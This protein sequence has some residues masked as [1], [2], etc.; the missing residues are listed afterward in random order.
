M[1]NDRTGHDPDTDNRVGA[2][3]EPPQPGLLGWLRA[4]RSVLRDPH[5]IIPD[6]Q[7][8]PEGEPLSESLD[9]HCPECNYN[10]TGLREWR[11]P[12]CGQRFDPRRA[13]TRRMLQRPEYVLRYRFDPA[14]IRSS[15]LAI[16]LFAA[17][18]V[19]ILAGGPIALQHGAVMFVSFLGVW[20]L[21]NMILARTQ[22][23][24]PWPNFLMFLSVLWLI[25]SALL[26]TVVTWM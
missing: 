9:L 8:P 17:G 6:V 13:H 2:P 21:P 22:G 26:L 18:V 19:L 3:P 7:L 4:W 25:A 10:L 15:F 12:E 14:E 1:V 11:C 16:L 24:W 20:I 5:K 23:G